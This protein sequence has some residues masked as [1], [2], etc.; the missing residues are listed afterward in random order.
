[1]GNLEAR[2]TP[3]ALYDVPRAVPEQCVQCV[4]AHR[5]AGGP[6]PSDS[7]VVMRGCT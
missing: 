6:L 3:W 1:M 7:V 4:R 2:S 5:P